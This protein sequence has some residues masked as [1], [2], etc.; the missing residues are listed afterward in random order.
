M[1]VKSIFAGE[2]VLA[3]KGANLHCGDEARIL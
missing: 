2:A 3:A 1:E